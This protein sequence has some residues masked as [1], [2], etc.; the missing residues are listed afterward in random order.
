MSDRSLR[1]TS[2]FLAALGAGI[3]AYLLYVRETGSSLVCSTGGCETVQ[4]SGYAEVLGLPVAALGLA[5]FLALFGAAL[6]RGEL[7]RLTQATLGLSA[8]LF[9]AYLL[10]IQLFVLDALCQWCLA[11]DLLTTA[12]ATLALVRLRPLRA[13]G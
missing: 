5:G 4:S 1:L 12:I 13:P 10:A 9:A 7:A 2:A 6:V 11:T 3:S 8:F